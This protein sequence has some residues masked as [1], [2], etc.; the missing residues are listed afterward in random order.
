MYFKG[1]S[2]MKMN[3][4]EDLT[5]LHNLSVLVQQTRSDN[6]NHEEKFEL[7]KIIHIYEKTF[8]RPGDDL[9][10]TNEVKHTIETENKG[11]VYTKSYR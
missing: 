7:N 8:Y 6:L 9:S 5:E 10:F 1:D 2:E 3:P 4:T 11:P